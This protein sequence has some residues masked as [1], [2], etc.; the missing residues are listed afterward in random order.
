MPPPLASRL[1]RQIALTVFLVVAAAS[2]AVL[3]ALAP[4]HAAPGS[5]LILPALLAAL[6]AAAVTSLIAARTI[7][8]PLLSIREGIRKPEGDARLPIDRADEIGDIARAVAEAHDRQEKQFAARIA[9]L[10]GSESQLRA[11]LE[12]MHQGVAMYDA[13]YKLVTWNER[14]REYLDMPDEFFSREHGFID[15]LRYNAA[16]GDFGDADAETLIAQ[17]LDL[18]KRVHSLE[19][20]RPNGTVLEITRAPTPDGGFIAIYTDVTERKTAEAELDQGQAGSGG[21]EPHEIGLPRQYEPRAAHAAQCDHRLQPDAPGG[22]G[23]RRPGPTISRS[24]EDRERRQASARPHQRHPR[25]FQD[26]GRAA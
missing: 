8:S 11:T 13:D 12:N 4:V 23:G 16:R 22:S 9:D 2:L 7:V 10:T 25:S 15:Y 5:R 19:R 3:L 6:I 20:T 17:R 14:F 21:R 18:L 1:S 26:R 24:Q